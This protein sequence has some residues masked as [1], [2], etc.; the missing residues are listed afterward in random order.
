MDSI[1]TERSPERDELSGVMQMYPFGSTGPPRK[2][3][4][5]D[6]DDSIHEAM[7]DW[8]SIWSTVSGLFK[9][10]PIAPSSGEYAIRRITARVK[11]GSIMSG[12]ATRRLPG[13]KMVL[14]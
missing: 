8:S 4:D 6:C 2:I 11:W 13:P 5:G 7:G 1:S 9:M 14:A 12:V 10:R 3:V